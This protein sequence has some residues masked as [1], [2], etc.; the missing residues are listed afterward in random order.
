MLDTLSHGM[1]G[2][3]E[4][5]SVS[6]RLA[7]GTFFVISGAHKLFHPQRRADLLQTFK[8]DNVPVPLPV[9]M[10]AIPLGEFFGGV[11]LLVGFL[12]LPACAGLMIICAGA[13]VLDGFKRIRGMHPL[14]T[15][16]AL[17][18]VLYLPE[19]LYILMIMT[20]VCLGPGRWSL[21]ALLFR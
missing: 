8:A 19:V 3:V 5:A 6:S 16:D 10:W 11:A 18:D 15:A 4:I 20:L 21:D 14:D 7:L 12:T 9:A 1:M 2:G 13:C 17:D